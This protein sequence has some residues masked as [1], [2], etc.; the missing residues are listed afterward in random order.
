MSLDTIPDRT[1]LQTITEDQSWFNVLKQV[2]IQVLAP[3]NSSGVVS[4]G[5]AD[6]GDKTNYWNN[7][8]GATLKLLS[9]SGKVLTIRVDPA[10]QTDLLLSSSNLVKSGAVTFPVVSTTM[11]DIPGLE[12]VIDTTGNPVQLVLLNKPT[13]PSGSTGG[14]E[15]ITGGG[16]TVGFSFL[17]DGV[18]IHFTQLFWTGSVLII[19]Y[20]ALRFLDTGAGVGRHVY[21][22][23][24]NNTEGGGSTAFDFFQV[25]LCAIERTG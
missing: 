2:L 9:N 25:C 1:N 24:A 23:Q 3:R 21:K 10:L 7:F 4:P 14:I 5:S 22:V 6:L 13:L 17:R 19:P 16:Q 20:S 11:A 8:Y 18:P 15:V 12:V